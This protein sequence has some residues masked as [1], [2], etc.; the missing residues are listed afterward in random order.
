[1]MNPT[2]RVVKVEA[3]ITYLP[4]MSEHATFCHSLV[5]WDIF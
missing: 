3:E 4:V 5:F 2:C 1:M